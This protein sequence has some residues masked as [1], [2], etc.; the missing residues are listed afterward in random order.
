MS[1]C[2]LATEGT[3]PAEVAKESFISAALEAYVLAQ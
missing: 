2:K 3:I 1:D